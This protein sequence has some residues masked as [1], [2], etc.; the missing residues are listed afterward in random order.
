[1]FLHVT[2]NGLGQSKN[3]NFLVFFQKRISG[4]NEC[5]FSLNGIDLCCF[6]YK[7][8]ENHEV[9]IKMGL[10]FGRMQCKPDSY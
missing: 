6:S 3:K 8:T 9:R 2:N 1:M 10:K 7:N 4:R 5:G